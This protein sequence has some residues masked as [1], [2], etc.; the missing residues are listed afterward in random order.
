MHLL[1]ITPMFADGVLVQQGS[2]ACLVLLTLAA[3]LRSH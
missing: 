1:F 3:L 2:A